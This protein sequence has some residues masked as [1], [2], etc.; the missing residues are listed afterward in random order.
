LGLFNNR[1][2]FSRALDPDLTAVAFNEFRVAGA[3]SGTD[4][5]FSVEASTV[6]WVRFLGMSDAILTPESLRKALMSFLIAF[7]HRPN[8]AVLGRSSFS[9]RERQGAEIFRDRCENCHEARLV[10]DQ[11]FS[12]AAFD[13][14]ETLV[15]AREGAIVWGKDVYEKTGVLPYVHESG[16]RVPSLR[17]LYKKHP[18]FTN[19]SAD[20]LDAVLSRA[21]LLPAGFQ[22]E[23]EKGDASR[24][25]EPLL[26]AP[27]RDA[28]LTFLAL[29]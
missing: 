21:R 28:L 14:W 23:A 10:S 7:Q 11:Q 9:D 25:V 27:S 13:R 12:R 17:R 22:H 29:L 15:M 20:S 26:D 16:A 19:G 2:H 18:Y 6:P 4:P 3:K 5:W 24:D 1:P 8:P